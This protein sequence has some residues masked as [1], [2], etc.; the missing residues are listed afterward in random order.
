MPLKH[1]G[2]LKGRAIDRQLGAGQSPHYQVLIVDDKDEYRI[3]V[4]VAS[5]LQ[6]SE[7]EYLI[8][9]HFSHPFL[10][11][12]EALGAGWHP[13][14][15]KPGGPALDF[16]RTNLFDPRE[17]VPL[18]FNVPGPDNDLNEKIDHYIQRALADEDAMVYA[19]GERWGPE[20]GKRDK[21]FGFEPGNGVHDI[22]MNQGNVGRFTKDDGVYQ[23]GAFLLHFPGQ[24]QWVGIFLKFQSQSWH[25][26][27]RTGH[28]IKVPVSGPPSDTEVELSPFAPGSRP[29]PQHPDGAIRI[30]AALVNGAESPEAE[31][32]TLLNTTNAE[33]DLTGWSLA[34]QEKKKTSLEGKLTAGSTTR[35]KVTNPMALSNK[36][37]LITL[38]NAEG[39]RVDGVSYTRA[40]ASLPG[41]TIKF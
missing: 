35:V 30:V 40:S 8:D 11:Q 31:F 29:T 39:L 33:I 34:D 14:A 13:L 28:T 12:F 9:D 23:D 24:Q 1:Y 20:P 25:T 32:V 38:L 3:A 36:G 6:P 19:V 4:N 17:M 37:G 10:A 41:F 2:V 15:P 22:H 27:D 18:P 26:D 5:Q 7:L 21:I 16:I